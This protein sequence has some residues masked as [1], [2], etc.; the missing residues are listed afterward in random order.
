MKPLRLMLTF[1]SIIMVCIICVCTVYALN[2]DEATVSV[3]WSSQTHLSGE[4]ES[5]TITFKSK[6]S[7]MLTI[8]NIGL[9]FDWMPTD[10]FY[11]LDL[12]ANPAVIPSYGGYTFDSMTFL[13]TSSTSAGAHSYFV[14]IDGREGASASVFSWDSPTFMIQ[15]ESS[16]SIFSDLL[17]QVESK[18]SEADNANYESPDARSLVTQAK[19]DHELALRSLEEEENWQ[20][21]T[22]ALQNASDNLDQANLEE[23][24]FDEQNQ[25]QLLIIVA[26]IIAISTVSIIAVIVRKRRKQKLAT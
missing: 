16:E 22:S 25:T 10:G 14:G 19:N 5:A 23:Q 8:Y 6:S 4:M 12:S 15:I 2:P 21:A 18:I 7:E 20:E 17:S 3:S 9:H 13:I 24:R 11:G 26:V 1:A